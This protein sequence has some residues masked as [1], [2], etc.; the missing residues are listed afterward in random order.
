MQ[1]PSYGTLNGAPCQGYAIDFF[2][3]ISKKSS[4]LWETSNPNTYNNNN[5]RRYEK[6]SVNEACDL[7]GLLCVLRRQTI[8]QP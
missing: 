5:Q 2:L 3:L 7:D 6:Q 4:L 8:F 1:C